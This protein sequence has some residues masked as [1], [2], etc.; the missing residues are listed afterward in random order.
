MSGEARG[1]QNSRW[2]ESYLVRYLPGTV[3]G[4]FCVFVLAFELKAIVD[5]YGFKVSFDGASGW[6]IVSGLILGLVFSYISSS[7]ITLI[8][9]GRFDK[10]YIESK[11]RYF[12]LSW[13]A[14]LIFMSFLPDNYFRLKCI[15]LFLSAVFFIGAFYFYFLDKKGGREEKRDDGNNN[16]LKIS[17]L[18]LWIFGV[19]SLPF[20][21]YDFMVSD[22]LRFLFMSSLPAIWVGLVQYFTLYRVLGQSKKIRAEYWRLSVARQDPKN[23]DLRET[24]QH[25]R[26]H[27]NSIFILVLEASLTAFIIF[28]IRF[29]G[30]KD[31]VDDIAL[32]LAAF[33]ALWLVPT[34]FMWSRANDLEKFIGRID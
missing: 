25:L 9:Y 16:D 26:E 33:L 30:F 3:F 7:P 32:P 1:Y 29:I 23:S 17:E 2:W 5:H 19:I 24:Y 14:A 11:T 21:L 18:F 4:G 8:H 28:L 13:V 6:G 12:W 20:I 10:G 31:G 22:L 27:S 15:G 34:I